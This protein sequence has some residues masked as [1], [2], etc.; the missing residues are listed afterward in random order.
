L[1]SFKTWD[2]MIIS[3]ICL[4]FLA[5]AYV[6]KC[7]Q[8]SY[9]CVGHKDHFS[10]GDAPTEI[11]ADRI[12]YLVFRRGGYFAL[13]IGVKGDEGVTVVPECYCV[14][15]GGEWVF[16]TL[17]VEVEFSKLPRPVQ[18]HILKHKLRG[19]FYY[20]LIPAVDG[21]SQPF[22]SADEEKT[23]SYYENIITSLNL[24]ISEQQKVIDSGLFSPEEFNKKA[25]NAS[26]SFN[27]PN[28]VS[29]KERFGLG[30]ESQ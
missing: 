16:K 11:Y 4:Y 24:V 28:T 14:N 7:K 27:K 2:V 8:L 22:D 23:A 6:D 17:P 1:T 13:G 26:Q 10:I 18:S 15:F 21:G 3:A 12:S 20:N 25:S 29:L 19:P 30:G 5:G 9:Q